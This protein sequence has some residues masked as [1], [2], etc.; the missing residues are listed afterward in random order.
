MKILIPH[1]STPS[2]KN[3]ANDALYH[4]LEVDTLA[5]TMWGEARN[6][7]S[8]GMQAVAAVIINRTKISQQKQKFW[9]GSTLIQICQKPYQFSCW[10]RTDPNFQKLLHVTKEN[11]YFASALR[12]ARRAVYNRIDDPTGGADHYHASG[13]FP[14]WAKGEKPT[15]VIGDHIFYRLTK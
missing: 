5:R 9:W 12:I 1:A 14:L 6:Q 2:E 7:G 13:I 15:A 11:I 8:I 3:I 10:N 4:E